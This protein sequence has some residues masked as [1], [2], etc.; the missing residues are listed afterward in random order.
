MKPHAYSFSI[1]RYPDD[2][3]GQCIKKAQLEKGLSQK[4]LA[5]LAQVDE[6]TMVNWEKSKRLPQQ[7][8][9]VK[10]L[11][12]VL[13]VIYQDVVESFALDVSHQGF[14][15]TLRKARI[16]QG[17]KQEE[18]ATLAGIDPTTLRKWEHWIVAPTRADRQKLMNLCRVLS[19]PYAD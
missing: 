8:W 7:Y 10:D 6:M 18:A 16:M 3:F 9:R 13:E 14:G 12:N 5:R 19:T 4:E 11:C 17:L 1:S 2:T 15:P